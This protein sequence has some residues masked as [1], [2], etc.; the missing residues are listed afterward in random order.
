MRLTYLAY[1]GPLVPGRRIKVMRFYGFHGRIF[2]LI[3]SHVVVNGSSEG[4]PYPSLHTVDKMRLWPL[5]HC[6]LR[7]AMFVFCVR[8]AVR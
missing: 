8:V 4:I 3:Y 7:P 6:R 2:D 5:V 1:L